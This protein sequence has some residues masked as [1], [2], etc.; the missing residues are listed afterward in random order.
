MNRVAE[1]L[2]KH[3][4]DEGTVW[5]MAMMTDELLL[6]N[7]KEEPVIQKLIEKS[8]KVLEIRIF[9][10]NGEHRLFRSDIGQRDPEFY[11]RTILDTGAQKDGRDCFDQDQYLD[12]DETKGHKDGYVQTTG[13]GRYYLPLGNIHN[14]R[15]RIRYYL[16]KYADTGHARVADWRIVK[17]IEGGE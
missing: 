16:E 15:I 2:E 5:V 4:K 11:E 14:A 17:L 12:I 8:G 7:C 9:G 13:G 3:G 1:F 10:E 6:G